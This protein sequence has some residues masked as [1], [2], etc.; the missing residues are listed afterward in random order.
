MLLCQHLWGG[1]GPRCRARARPAQPTHR[2]AWAPPAP[3]AGD[4]APRAAY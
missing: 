3:A 2:A 4:K 1:H